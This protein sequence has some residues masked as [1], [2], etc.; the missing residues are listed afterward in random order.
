MRKNAILFFIF[1]GGISDLGA[2]TLSFQAPSLA[3]PHYRISFPFEVKTEKILIQELLL[4]GQKIDPFLIFKDGKNVAS[5]APLEKGTY[6]IVLDYAWTSGKKYAATL[7]WQTESSAT[8]KRYQVQ[9]VSPEKGGIPGGEEGFYRLY[10]IE[11]PVG[12]ERKGEICTLVLTAARTD[13]EAG[14]F[15][16]F[17][18]QSEIPYQILEKKESR[19]PASAASN[20]PLTLSY[21]LAFPLD[22]QPKE[23]KWL[24]LV[25][26]DRKIKAEK[27]FQMSGEGLGKTVATNRLQLSFHPQ[28]GQIHTIDDRSEGIHLFNK[29]GVLHWNPDV[30]VPGIAWDHSFDWN[31]PAVFEER[32]GDFLYV[33]LRQGPLARIQ[34][35]FLQVKYI[36]EID[37]PYFISETL[38][39][40]SNDLGVIAVRNDEMVLFR[41]LFD[42]FIYQ[43]R[44]GTLVQGPLREKDRFPFGLVHIAPPDADWVGLINTKDHFGFFS[45]RIDA[46]NKNIGIPGEFLH[47]PGTYFYAPAD[48]NYV[49]WVRPLIYTWAD[50]ATN[51][52]LT[53]VPKGSFFYEK[54]AYLILRVGSD[55]A[56]KIQA[57]L[58]Q[59]RNPLRIF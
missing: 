38:L 53:L 14:N 32:T 19:P 2:T 34:D 28:S 42:S 21:K 8:P 16:V 22:A 52:L 25:R 47:R 46:A 39:T 48:G 36:L 33:N 24:L 50:Y 55:I 23:K 29:A 15:V 43:T 56:E 44:E 35:A 57:F 41:E 40:F 58:R 10:Q 3:E 17:D 5:S 49:Y 26:G 11:E 7:S 18:G 59:L 51:N 6:D 13:I 54:N 1:F 30:F 4:N 20:H 27:T 9:G 12:L 45:L 37:S 31:P